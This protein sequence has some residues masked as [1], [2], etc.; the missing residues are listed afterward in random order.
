MYSE[1]EIFFIRIPTSAIERVAYF[2]IW[3]VIHWTLALLFTDD[4]D[5]ATGRTQFFAQAK[6]NQI[7]IWTERCSA[8]LYSYPFFLSLTLVA[9]HLHTKYYEHEPRYHCRF[10]LYHISDNMFV[11]SHVQQQKWDRTHL[12]RKF[13][14]WNKK[15]L[16]LFLLGKQPEI[17]ISYYRM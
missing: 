13:S 14:D 10:D 9:I 15:T 7:Y 1:W 16:A 5:D 4:D 17:I 12:L 6:K 11:A 8:Q 2:R 3:I